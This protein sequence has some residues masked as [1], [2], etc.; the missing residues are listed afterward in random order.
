M[1]FRLTRI[2][3]RLYYQSMYNEIVV[4]SWS[5]EMLKQDKFNQLQPYQSVFESTTDSRIKIIGVKI[6]KPTQM[7]EQQQKKTI[8]VA[9][10]SY[11]NLHVLQ[12]HNLII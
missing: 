1:L 6:L 2:T 7:L 8:Q 11:N 5:T 12:Q 4:K 10:T 3:F 9:I